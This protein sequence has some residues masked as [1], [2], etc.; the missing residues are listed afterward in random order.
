MLE[1]ALDCV[2]LMDEAGRIVQFNPAAEQ[3]FGYSTAEAVG[4]E[5]AALIIPPRKRACV[6][7]GVRALSR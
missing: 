7:H 5:L 1:V 6:P 4:A 2:I 3:T